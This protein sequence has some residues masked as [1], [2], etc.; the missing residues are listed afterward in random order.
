MWCFWCHW[1][2]E[3]HFVLW[4]IQPCTQT[5]SGWT[6]K[7][8]VSPALSVL[9][10]ANA[11]WTE[12]DKNP[13][14]QVPK[15]DATPVTGRRRP[16]RPSSATRDVMFMR[17]DSTGHLARRHSSSSSTGLTTASCYHQIQCAQCS[18]WLCGYRLLCQ[19]R[20]GLINVAQSST[21]WK[22]GRSL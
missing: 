12:W 2:F 9:D 11:L 22:M 17:P 10:L 14:S 16:P 21:S 18:M 5:P 7:P 4:L 13:P 15:S 20:K 1:D 19:M 3:A 6:G 8:S